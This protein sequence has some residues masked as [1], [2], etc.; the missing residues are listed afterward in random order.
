MAHSRE[1]E[2]RVAL[3]T[4]AASGIGKATAKAFAEAGAKLVLAD[5]QMQ[6]GEALARELSHRGCATTFLPCDISST[7]D[8]HRLMDHVRTR[9]GRLDAAFNN[10]GIEGTPAS[11]ELCTLENW[12]RTLEVNLRGTF[13]CMRE[14]IP[15]LRE[16]GGGS[17][18][19]CSSI[20]GL[21]GFEGLPAYVASKHAVIGLT[22]SAAL[23]LATASIRVNAVCPGV[24][25]TPMVIRFTGGDAKAYRELTEQAPMHRAGR[26]EEIASAVLFLCSPAASFIT[27]QT[28]VVDGGWLVR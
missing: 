18:V 27:G 5:L 11:T 16:S 9:H 2:G 19:N 20:A 14:E 4:G 17:I 1:W 3:V 24:I 10:A 22:R 21:V 25:D 15:L 6:A 13:L 12:D 8:V 26:P 7:S 23:E 28:L